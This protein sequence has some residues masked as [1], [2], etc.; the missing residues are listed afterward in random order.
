MLHLFSKKCCTYFPGNVAL[1]LYKISIYFKNLCAK[2]RT[3]PIDIDTNL[4][5]ESW[6]TGSLYLYSRVCNSET[7]TRNTKIDIPKYSHITFFTYFQLAFSIDEDTA[8]LQFHF[9]M[10][11]EKQC[12]DKSQKISVGKDNYYK[13][14]LQEHW[15]WEGSY[16][17]L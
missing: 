3:T 5:Y 15:N 12:L 14:F 11:S 4:Y 7:S 2:T 16:T 6:Y 1:I 13:K 10:Y 17:A 8:H 9:R